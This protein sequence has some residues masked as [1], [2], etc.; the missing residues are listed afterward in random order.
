METSGKLEEELSRLKNVL[1]GLGSKP[2]AYLEI[3][4]EGY[5]R[6]VLHDKLLATL[7]ELVLSL[8]V[9]YHVAVE[10]DAAK[11]LT[12][13]FNIPEMIKEAVKDEKQARLATQLF[14][15][16][17]NGDEEQAKSIAEDYYGDM[18]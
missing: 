14:K 3:D 15:A 7:S 2:L 16:L 17:S 8:R 1:S 9:S 18:K 11:I 4:S 6:K 5:D 12:R 13:T 10:R